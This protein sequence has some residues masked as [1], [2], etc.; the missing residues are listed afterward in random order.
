MND[1]GISIAVRFSTHRNPLVI[2][3]MPAT[4]KS[5]LELAR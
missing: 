1:M 3:I 5:W 2:K 4:K